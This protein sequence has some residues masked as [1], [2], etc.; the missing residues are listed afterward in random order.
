MCYNKKASDCK[1]VSAGTIGTY[2]SN[3]AWIG[4]TFVYEY[5]KNPNCN[6]D[7]TALNLPRFPM[8]LPT[9]CSKGCPSV[10]GFQTGGT[11]DYLGCDEEGKCLIDYPCDLACPRCNS[12]NSKC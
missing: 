12:D 4:S 6:P 8:P 9:S 1:A 5:H 7:G 10:I 11:I 3:M 2:F